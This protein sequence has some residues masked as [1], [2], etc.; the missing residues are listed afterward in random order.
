MNMKFL[1]DEN[2]A[3]S[4]VKSLR[5]M[6]FDVKDVKEE[7]LYGLKDK[8]L[9]KLGAKEDRV[10][11]THD[12]DFINLA[13]AKD[14]QNRGIILLRFKNQKALKIQITLLKFLNSNL[15]DKANKGVIILSDTQVI[16][17][18]PH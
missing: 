2:V 18:S 3:V 5:N 13:L 12:K 17:H 8:E 11:I 10:I 15:K 14:L 1:T 9:L 16:V 6:K 7:K 4:L